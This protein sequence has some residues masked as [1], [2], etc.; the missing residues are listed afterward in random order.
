MDDDRKL[1]QPQQLSAGTVDQ[2]YFSVRMAVS[3]ML[4]DE[5]MPLILD[6]SFVLYDDERLI[7]SDG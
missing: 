1:L 2:I 4:Y 3:Q 7:H 5:P 6:D